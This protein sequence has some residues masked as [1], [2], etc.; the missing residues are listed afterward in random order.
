ME[1]F[2]F[3]TLKSSL[4]L[5]AG[6]LLYFLLL[7]R[8]TFH[9]FKRFTLIG[10]IVASLLIPL[11]R[12]NLHSTVVSIPVQKLE[13][14]ILTETPVTTVL[15]QTTMPAMT[16][17]PGHFT[18]R[19]LLLVYLTGAGL[20]AILILFA[21]AR[22]II[23][24]RKSEKIRYGN[25][26]LAVTTSSIV[27]FCF[28]RHIL[29]SRK[30]LEEN[31]N[32]ILLHEMTHLKKGH[33]LDLIL[34]EAYLLIT[35]YNP[36]SWLIRKELKQNHEFEADRNVLRQ[37]IDDSYYQLLL[38]RTVAGEQRYRLAN[39]FNQS[40]LKTRIVMMNKRK[41]NSLAILKAALYQPTRQPENTSGYRSTS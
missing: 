15:Q 9:R 3:Y 14:T 36:F 20:Q 16:A 11:I 4:C 33:N 8:E 32:A 22:I 18:I 39:S 2:I 31:K 40:N 28:G 27:P 23:I 24:F 38:V 26:R 29:I 6:Y 10:I 21:L 19:P 17:Q 37:G 1:S 7:R 35:W 34:L 25:M 13:T 12:I 41:S 30:D 5:S